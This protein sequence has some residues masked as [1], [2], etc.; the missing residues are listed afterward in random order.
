[1]MYVFHIDFQRT[2]SGISCSPFPIAPFHFRQEVNGGLRGQ[3]AEGQTCLHL[4]A[5]GQSLSCSRQAGGRA[6]SRCRQAL[7][8]LCATPPARESQSLSC[9]GQAGGRA[10]SRAQKGTGSHMCDPA[11]QGETADSRGAVSRRHPL[12]L[13]PTVRALVAAPPQMLRSRVLTPGGRNGLRASS[14]P[15][16]AWPEYGLL[17]VVAMA[18]Q[19]QLHGTTR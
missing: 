14:P 18:D 6:A 7:Q 13:S 9:S 19:L 4:S 16:C 2:D 1:M 11:G 15:E 5:G 17:V 12:H 3:S 10:P 8:A